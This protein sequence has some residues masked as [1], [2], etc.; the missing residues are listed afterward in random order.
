MTPAS[1][2][3]D[4]EHERGDDGG[5]HDPVGGEEKGKPYLAF[6]VTVRPGARYFVKVVLEPADEY[7]VTLTALRAGKFTEQGRAEGVYCDNLGEVIYRLC[8]TRPS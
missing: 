1:E 6:D 7:T 3:G 4:G 2:A 5:E 8:N